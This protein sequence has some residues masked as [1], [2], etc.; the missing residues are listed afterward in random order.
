MLIYICMYTY[1][2]FISNLEFFKV[3]RQTD[4]RRVDAICLIGRDGGLSTLCHS[5]GFAC[6]Q[7]VLKTFPGPGYLHSEDGVVWLWHPLLNLYVYC[8]YLACMF[9]YL[10]IFKKMWNPQFNIKA[11][12][13]R[14]SWYLLKNNILSAFHQ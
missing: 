1:T 13:K 14:K 4:F 10:F 6:Q 9:S 2:N 5:C 7:R 3:W 8:I 11:L 12:Q